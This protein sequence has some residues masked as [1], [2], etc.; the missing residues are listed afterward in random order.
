MLAP[1]LLDVDNYGPVSLR[2]VDLKPM[3]LS[4]CRGRWWFYPALAGPVGVAYLFGPH[5]LNSGPVFNAIGF[6]A[7]VAIVVGVRRHRPAARWAWFLLALSQAMF[8][9]GDVL[10]YNYRAL[11]GRALPFPS[12]ADP[13][14]LAV[15]P[16]VVGGLLVMIRRRNPGRDWASLIDATI[17]T[18]GLGLLSWVVLMAPYAHDTSL[19][20]AAK[21]VS[22]AYP[23]GDILVLGVAVRMAVGGGRRSAA[24]F[25]LIVGIGAL[26]VTDSIYGCIQ[27]HGVYHPGDLLDGGWIVYY[28]LLGCAALHPSMA[29]ISQSAAPTP[30]L[31]RSRVLG[32]AAAAL[33]AP[34]IEII[35]AASD[36]GSDALIIGVVA[37]VLFGLVVIRVIG[38]ARAQELSAERERTMRVAR[39][40]LV[41]ATSPAEIVRAAQNAATMLAGVEAIPR[42]MLVEQRDGATCLV[43]ERFGE[44]GQPL[45]VPVASLSQDSVDRLVC[46]LPLEIANVQAALDSAAPCAPGVLWPFLVEG[47]LAGAIALF[48]AA[49]LSVALRES[50]EALAGQVGLALE[51]AA[52]TEHVLRSESEQHFS[53][54]V[55]H[56]SD[57]IFVLEPDTTVKYASPSVQR[58]LGYEPDQLIGQRLDGYMPP[59]DRALVASAL[60]GLRPGS[61]DSS[62]VLEFRVRHRDGAWLDSESLVTSLLDNA[63]VGGIVMN[64]RDITERK[65]FEQQLAHQAFH[66]PVT[67]LANRALLGDRVRHALVSRRHGG[68]SIAILFLDLDGFK[69]V[70]DTFGHAAGDKLLCTV[71]SRLEATVRVGDTIA[72]LGG[73]EFAMLLDGID[74]EAQISEIAERL[75]EVVSKPI[76]VEGHVIYVQCSIGIAVVHPTR[77][78]GATFDGLLRGAD[79]AM[80]Q[81]KT[82]GGDAYRY[83]NAEMY[84]ELTEQLELRADL[85]A[86]IDRDELTLVYQPVFSIQTR[87]IVGYEALS[88]WEHPTRGTISPDSFIPVAENSGLI[89]GL[90]CRVLERACS[91]AVIFQRACPTQPPRMLSVNLSPRQLQR[92]E[93]VDEV[94]RALTTS[95]LEPDRLLLEI[96]ESLM[97]DH[98]ELAIERLNA[99][100]DLGVLI[101]VDDFGTGYSS[102]S[103]IRRLPIH[104]LKIDKSF[105]DDIDS[106]DEQR[107]LT[108]AIIDLSLALSLRC[109]AE[110]IERT[111]Q[112]ERLKDLGC[113]YAQGFLL[114][115]PLDAAALLEQLSP[116][117]PQL[118]STP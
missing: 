35:K 43:A 58:V 51:S 73:D 10:A 4:R 34:A 40:A 14:Y 11:L 83:F 21:L 6:S 89:V 13:V 69:Q 75:L 104:V 90:G 111:E 85:K 101:A 30:R 116:N 20:L 1:G 5:V 19:H 66:D 48:N 106:N 93:I 70:N 52:L 42:I 86:A 114:G 46:G 108:A 32:I 12:V 39:G 105:I 71:S 72:R 117:P 47:Q 98:V 107:K 76:T 2:T 88:R 3:R 7:C 54:L 18:I 91:D 17:L 110:G 81:A 103:Y 50:L 29:T 87:E 67:K 60:I 62:E 44:S 92:P 102:L 96:T 41:T 53:A 74:H 37:A 99:L 57:V 28:V 84:A 95:G 80:Y 22:I 61:A 118:L 68:Q 64:L 97:I 27:L 26:L 36:D 100:R 63:S 112:L 56:S 78:S 23:L 82:S 9:L 113:G 31:T 109:V 65:Q 38:L 79:V 115:R 59:K 94:Q 55:Q 33:I 49:A 45:S 8:V 15:Y 77:E 16:L 25:M 24:Y